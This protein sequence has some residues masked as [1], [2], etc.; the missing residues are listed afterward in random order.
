MFF[1]QNIKTQ[2]ITE[3][4]RFFLFSAQGNPGGV[5]TSKVGVTG[6]THS[7]YKS[8]STFFYFLN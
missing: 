2:N 4:F 3:M 7:F 1:L 8:N 6:A 5:L